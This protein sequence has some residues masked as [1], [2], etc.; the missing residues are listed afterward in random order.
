MQS[1]KCAWCFFLANFVMSDLT[2]GI[3]QIDNSLRDLNAFAV[4][5]V[6]GIS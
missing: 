5:F 3:E 2:P 1:P 4:N 6:F